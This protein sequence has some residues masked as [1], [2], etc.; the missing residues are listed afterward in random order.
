ML[1][2]VAVH[3]V[4]RLVAGQLLSQV[5]YWNVV[6][7]LVQDH[8][9]LLTVHF[10]W[11]GREVIVLQLE[12]EVTSSYTHG[13][14][15]RYYYWPSGTGTFSASPSPPHWC[16]TVCCRRPAMGG[17]WE[18]CWNTPIILTILPLCCE[19]LFLPGPMNHFDVG[20]VGSGT[21]ELNN[22]RVNIVIYHCIQSQKRSF[23]DFKIISDNW[24]FIFR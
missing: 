13:W 18:I 7:C 19:I 14:W 23:S 21:I 20:W 15:L 8:Q 11:N 9:L 6:M 3:H 1:H 17:W 22:I 2:L 12:R 4:P 16:R 24:R 5:I 10:D